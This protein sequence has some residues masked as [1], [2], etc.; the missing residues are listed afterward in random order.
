MCRMYTFPLLLTVTQMRSTC[1]KQHPKILYYR[2]YKFFNNDKF[3]DELQYEIQRRV[4]QTIGCEIFE[5]LFMTI[6]NKHAPQ[7]KRLVR[8]NN[9]PFM[10]NELYKAIMVS[11][12]LR[13]KFIKS[14]CLKSRNNYK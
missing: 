5:N 7:K 3:I 1:E 11:W 10:N 13:N 14:K 2:N 12:R 8:A 4:G 6:L 9:S